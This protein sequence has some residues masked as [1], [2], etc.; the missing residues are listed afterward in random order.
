MD[1]L[2]FFAY[3]RGKI[4]VFINLLDED[5]SIEVKTGDVLYSTSKYEV[6][7]G[8]IVIAAHQAII[9]K[10]PC[11]SPNFLNLSKFSVIPFKSPIPSPF[12]SAKLETNM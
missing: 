3:R 5:Q 2:I 8:K 7:R 12:E 4:I 10:E 6:V 11:G 9:Y 1:H